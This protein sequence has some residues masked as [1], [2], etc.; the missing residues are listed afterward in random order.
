MKI[1]TNY[2]IIPLITILVAVLGSYFTSVG[3]SWYDT[4]LVQPELTPPKWAFPVAWNLIF[5]LTTISALLVWNADHKMRWS[6]LKLFKKN[7]KD[8]RW[9][10]AIG[11]FLANA[12]LN[13]LWSL[14]FFTLHLI[15]AALL[16]MLL[17]EATLVALFVLNWRFSKW[18]S[19]LLLPYLLW[20][21]FASYLTYTIWT[22]NI[23]LS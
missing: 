7:T 8:Q 4:T 18:A 15:G 17:L 14:L 23:V 21:G 2:V 19:F 20:I 1:K 3:M 5:I 13:V 11:L 22:L 12:I 16:E 6:F 9:H 10:W